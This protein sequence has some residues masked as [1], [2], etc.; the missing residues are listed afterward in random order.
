MSLHQPRRLFGD[1]PKKKEE[2]QK[3]NQLDPIPQITPQVS[4]QQPT[5]VTP[6]KRRLTT[7]AMHHPPTVIIYSY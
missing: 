3:G 1:A 7:P 6:K 4:D 5:P 2:K